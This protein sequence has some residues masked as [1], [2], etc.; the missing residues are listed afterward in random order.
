M[1][2]G[3]DGERVDDGVGED[4]GMGVEYA[5]GRG[6]GWVVHRLG[7]KSDFL[8]VRGE[9]DRRCLKRG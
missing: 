6:S 8:V 4:G 5:D 7:M 1:M 3:R 9:D 2:N